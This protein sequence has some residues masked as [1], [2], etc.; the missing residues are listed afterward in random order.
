[1]N[2]EVRTYQIVGTFYNGYGEEEELRNVRCGNLRAVKLGEV[3]VCWEHLRTEYG[4]ET[5]AVLE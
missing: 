4:F 5:S 3:W 1:M 2:C